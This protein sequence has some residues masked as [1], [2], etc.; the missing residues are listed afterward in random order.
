MLECP[1]CGIVYQKFEKEQQELEA[2]KLVVYVEKPNTNRAYLWG[3]VVLLFVIGIFMVASKGVKYPVGDHAYVNGIQPRQNPQAGLP[4]PEPAY[5]PPVTYTPPPPQ[6]H[7]TGRGLQ[8]PGYNLPVIRTTPPALKDSSREISNAAQPL[9]EA[10][11]Q[12]MDSSCYYKNELDESEW[13]RIKSLPDYAKIRSIA[14]YYHRQHTYVGNDWFVCLDMAMEVWDLLGTAGIRSRLMVGNVQTDITQSETIVKYLA[15][16]NHAWVLAEVAPSTWIA[17]ETT[18]GFIAQ[19]SMWNYGLYNT[20]AMFDNPGQLKDFNESRKSMFQTCSQIVPMQSD[21]NRSYAGRP[22]STKG[23]QYTGRII[24]KIYD[25]KN[26]VGRVTT[27]L[28]RN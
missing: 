15:A 16:M 11:N 22:V 7:Q 19:P 14:L 1:R 26:L 25:C 20:G 5:S 27:H 12:P 21:F 10:F 4:R 8:T 9:T 28:R 23:A 3:A 17:V 24:Q 6:N 13:D 2:A 18:G